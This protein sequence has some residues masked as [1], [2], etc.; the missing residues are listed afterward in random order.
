VLPARGY[1]DARVDDIVSAV[2]VS[3]GTFYRYFES[4]DDFFRV[5]AEEA[6]T[7]LIQLVDRLDLDAPADEQRAWLSDWFD[8]YEADGGV[9]ST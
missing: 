8:A 6:S 2:G 5:L 3:H 9:I 4:K 1:H 7:R